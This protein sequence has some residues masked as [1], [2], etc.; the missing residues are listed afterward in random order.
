MESVQEHGLNK[1]FL[2]VIFLLRREDSLLHTQ[3]HDTQLLQIYYS[4]KKTSLT[5]H[6]N[7]IVQHRINCSV[8]SYAVLRLLSGKQK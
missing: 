4:Q 8:W 5:I 7:Y 3:K 1:K 6:F 2:L